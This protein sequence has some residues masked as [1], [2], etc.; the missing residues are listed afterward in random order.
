MKPLL[1]ISAAVCTLACLCLVTCSLRANTIPISGTAFY[2]STT[3]FGFDITGASLSLHSASPDA[4][5]L[6]FICNQGVDCSLPAITVEAFTDFVQLP[7]FFSDGTFDSVTADTLEGQ[8]QFSGT[9]AF[10]PVSTSPTVEVSGP[11]TFSGEIIGFQLL[12]SGCMLDCRLG[13][14]VF[15]LSLDGTA[16]LTA[17]GSP[18]GPGVDRFEAWNYTIIGTASPVPEPAASGLFLLGAGL[19]LIAVKLRRV[20]C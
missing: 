14:T 10:V 17:I 8:I 6:D 15:T 5:S 13:T 11:V 2:R 20:I 18:L 9:T 16:T 19:V 12:P 7:G 1:R 3:T 4:G